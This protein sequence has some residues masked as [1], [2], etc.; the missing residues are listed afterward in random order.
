MPACACDHYMLI[1]L[2]GG[3]T[4]RYLLHLPH[5]RR[6]SVRRFERGRTQFV[7]P[8]WARSGDHAILGK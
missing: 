8:Q 7:L 2:L 4:D 6:G 5:V 3:S 1:S